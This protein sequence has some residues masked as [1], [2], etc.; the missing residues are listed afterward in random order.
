MSTEPEPNQ[1]A[2][3]AKGE[4]EAPKNQDAAAKEAAAKAL[5]EAK[6]K[7]TAGVEAFKTL[8]LD[9]QI[10]LAALAVTVLCSILFS[11]IGVSVQ[12]DGPMADILKKGASTASA[13]VIQAGANGL[14]AVLAAAAGIGLWIWNFKAKKKEAWAPLAIAGAAGLSGL[15]FLVLWLRSGTRSTDVG[16]LHI[17][18]H[19]TLLGFWLPFA[20]A[21]A[22]T[23]VSVKRIL[24]AGSPPPA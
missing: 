5:G 4:A 7:M 24:N 10:Y 14:F 3:P 18:V 20:G 8:S 22:A 9:A 11:A 15:L 6:Q 16:G 2:S 17:S 21:I 12:A 13:S 23:A 1:S 19:M